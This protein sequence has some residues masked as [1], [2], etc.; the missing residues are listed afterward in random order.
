[1]P[2][3]AGPRAGFNPAANYAWT[4][5]S[6]TSSITG[7]DAGFFNLNT[8]SFD[9]YNTYG[10]QFSLANSG[11]NFRLLYTGTGAAIP[12]PGTWLATAAYARCPRSSRW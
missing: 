10:R 7:F 9:P 4:I 11:N 6:A 3:T 2:S 8:A 12:E 1:M 5:V